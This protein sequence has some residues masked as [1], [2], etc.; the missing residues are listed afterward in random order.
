MAP[1]G[2]RSA[3]AL[4]VCTAPSAPNQQHPLLGT[5]VQERTRQVLGPLLPKAGRL[6]PKVLELAAP[7]KAAKR[8]AAKGTAQ[9]R[10][11]TFPR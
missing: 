4:L 1:R 8:P 3:C 7:K 10:P 6:Q 2:M 5:P 11:A 9:R